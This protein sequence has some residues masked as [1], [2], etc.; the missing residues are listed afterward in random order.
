MSTSSH[1][2]P[3]VFIDGHQGS[4]GLR[5][6][7][8]LQDRQDLELIRIDESLRKDP[9]ARRA[10]FES[11]DAAVLCL[12]DAASTEALELVDGLDV[13]IVDTASV[14]RVQ[15]DWTYGLPE[16]DAGQREAIR[17]SDRVA[18]PGCYPQSFILALRPLIEAG[19]IDA[20]LPFTVNAVSG[21]SGGG[22]G[23]VDAY[24]ARPARADGDASLPFTLYGLGGGHK[25]LPE[26]ARF[27]GTGVA[28]LF[29]P[30]VVHAITGMVV[31]IPLPSAWLEGL[32][33]ER[34]L[35]TWQIRYGEEPFVRLQDPA[36]MNE[37]LRDGKFL[38]LPVDGMGNDIELS[39][40]GDPDTGLLLVGRLDNLGKGASGNAVQCLNLMLGLPETA[41]L[42]RPDR[43]RAA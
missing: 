25:H 21:Y 11:A 33:P 17:G 40:F 32:T 20:S 3:R 2:R 4:T 27:G 6:M 14:R 42:T 19:L 7:S 24:R 15:P 18:N 43:A 35:Q 37:G 22:R 9:A 39:V 26:M 29:I 16:L 1:T 30:S 28:P 10:C 36:S 12:P 38:D 31:S 8:L 23:M 34:V 13:K 5:I 41:G